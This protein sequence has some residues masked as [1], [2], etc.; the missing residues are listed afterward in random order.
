VGAQVLLLLSMPV[1]SGRIVRLEREY[2][3]GATGQVF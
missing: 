1:Q 2:T 3:N